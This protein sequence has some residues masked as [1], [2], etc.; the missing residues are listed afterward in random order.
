MPD[1]TTSNSFIPKRNPAQKERIRGRKVYIGTLLV[2]ILFFA[3]LVGTV[4]V[5]F[6]ENKLNSNLEAEVK[7][8]TNA[9]STFEE[10]DMNKVLGFDARLKHLNYRFEYTASVVKILEAVEKATVGSVQIERI[11]IERT[12]DNAFDIESNI[13]TGSF[14][15]AL[16]QRQILENDDSLVVKEISDLSLQNVPP[17]GVVVETDGT[18]EVK[19]SFKATLE[20]DIDKIK[21]SVKEVAVPEITVPDDALLE[22]SESETTDENIIDEILS[23]ESDAINAETL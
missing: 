21:P 3:A 2:Q 8:L 22:D 16:F 13:V 18:E 9:I 7:S 23:D 20:V 1:Q 6:Y 10:D 19:V 17:D 14:D 15:S 12:S 4:G 5:Y 11:A